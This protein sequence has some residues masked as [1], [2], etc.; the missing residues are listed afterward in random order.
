[1][2]WPGK[3]RSSSK[4]I[5]FLSWKL[6]VGDRVAHLDEVFDR[7]VGDGVGVGLAVGFELLEQG[8]PMAAP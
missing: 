4:P 7:H 8:L 3:R 5:C 2:N 6:G 1:M